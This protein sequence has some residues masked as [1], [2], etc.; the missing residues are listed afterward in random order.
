VHAI[1]FQ[2]LLQNSNSC[3]QVHD[4]NVSFDASL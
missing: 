4:P 3:S 2:I 1:E